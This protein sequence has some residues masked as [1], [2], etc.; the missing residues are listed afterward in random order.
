[1]KTRIGFVSN[2]SSSSFI[3]AVPDGES[4]IVIIPLEI[5]LRDFSEKIITIDQWKRFLLYRN[6]YDSV[7]EINNNKDLL[8]MYKKGVE[9]INEGKYLLCGDVS[10]Q[11]EGIE[12][13]TLYHEK[14]K[15]S[16]DS[17]KI[18]QNIGED[19]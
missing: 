11:G 13:S 5:N 15:F 4:A 2:S 9:Q 12:Q 19:L 17:I 3:V 8:D 7:E 16:N 6:G 10:S 14:I 18:I 1:M